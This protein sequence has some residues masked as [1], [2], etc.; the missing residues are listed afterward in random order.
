MSFSA[1]RALYEACPDFVKSAIG[2]VPFRLTAGPVYRKVLRE[3][4]AYDR[5]SED[6]LSQLQSR[7]LG[8]S[9]RYAVERVP[10][11]RRQKS[12]VQKF[13]AEDAIKDFPTIDKDVVQERFEEFLAPDFEQRGHY[14]TSTG[15]TSGNQLRILLDDDSHYR[16]T[17]FIHSIWKRVGYSTSSK[18]ATFRGQ[19]IDVSENKFWRPNPIYRELQFS[20]FHLSPENID[21]YIQ[22]INRYSPAF[23]HG[24]PSVLSTLAGHLNSSPNLTLT[25]KPKAVLLGSEA[26]F[27]GQ[28]EAIEA[29]FQCRAFSWYG[30]SERLILGSECECDSSYHQVPNYGW[31]EILD[32]ERSVEVGESGELVGTTFWNRIMP[33]IRYRTGDHARRLERDC[34]CGRFHQ[35]FDAVQGRWN[36]EFLLGK[37]GAKVYSTALNMHG[38]AFARVHRYQYVQSKAGEVTVRLMPAIGFSDRDLEGIRTAHENRIG[39]DFRMEFEVVENIELSKRGKLKRILQQLPAGQ[40]S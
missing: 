33:L 35:R 31:L 12:A 30:H 10:F 25:A 37:S 27:D 20:T 40:T 23:L 9:L 1:K 3:T 11:Y 6:E 36:Q 2:C 21:L 17:A 14:E 7:L 8:E 18:K 38:D 29:G 39:H 22:A 26:T 15:G 28:R 32:G 16:E 34:C 4:L 5:L 13:P 19:V 24:Y